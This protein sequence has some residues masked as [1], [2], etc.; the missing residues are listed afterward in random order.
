MKCQLNFLT[1]FMKSYDAILL[2]LRI[3]RVVTAVSFPSR[4]SRLCFILAAHT[5]MGAH[6]APCRQNTVIPRLTKI[7]RSGIT[8]VSRN[9]T[10][11]RFL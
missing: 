5:C 4:V 9:V 11:R 10:S 7:I 3:A 1:A 2:K 6:P 8:F